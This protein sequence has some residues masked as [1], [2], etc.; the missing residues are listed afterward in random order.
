[1]VQDKIN[2]IN[3]A[4]QAKRE[5]IKERGAEIEDLELQLKNQQAEVDQVLEDK[6]RAIKGVLADIGKLSERELAQVAE[7][8]EWSKSEQALLD[9]LAV[10]IDQ[11]EAAMDFEP[12]DHG[13]YFLEP[14]GF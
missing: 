2:R 4:V 9:T 3:K 7:P 8:H 6:H 5:T 12:E 11:H 10:V 13:A 14:R 1:M